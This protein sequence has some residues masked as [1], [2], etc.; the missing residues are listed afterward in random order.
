MTGVE[1]V[2]FGAGPAF[3]LVISLV[4]WLC[5]G[6]YAGDNHQTYNHDWI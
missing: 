3:G 4:A 2:I 5:E 6:K 1:L